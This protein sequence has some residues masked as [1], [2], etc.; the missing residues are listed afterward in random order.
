[1]TTSDLSRDHVEL[2]IADARS[3][4]ETPASL[5]RLAAEDPD[6]A[7]ELDLHHARA[8]AEVALLT[9]ELDPA[10]EGDGQGE[11][12]SERDALE[13]QLRAALARRK[14]DVRRVLYAADRLSEALTKAFEN[15][16][17]I[18]L[19]TR[20]LGVDRSIPRIEAALS[21]TVLGRLRNLPAT[22]RLAGVA[23]ERAEHALHRALRLRP[24]ARASRA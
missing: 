20:R 16:R 3:A 14:K 6:S 11:A 23:V 7:K 15:E 21:A 2:R 1:M 19:I 17:L 22:P 18:R 8:Q 24:G 9:L 4:G 12:A 5:T 13:Q 10:A